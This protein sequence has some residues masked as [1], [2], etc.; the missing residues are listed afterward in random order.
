MFI[1]FGIKFII[2]VSRK[3]VAISYNS[4]RIVLVFVVRVNVASLTS[5]VIRIIAIIGSGF[6]GLEFCESGY[7][8]ICKAI[9]DYGVG[10]YIS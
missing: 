2:F 7:K 9:I 6:Y 5:I 8:V 3:L 4:S 10:G 1:I